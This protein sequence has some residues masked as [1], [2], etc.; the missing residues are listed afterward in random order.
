[1][2]IQQQ[3]A[4]TPG[5]IITALLNGTVQNPYPLYNS[6]RELDQGVHWAD[7]LDGWLCTRYADIRHIYSDDDTFSAKWWVDDNHN[8]QRAAADEHRRFLSIYTQQFML[9]DP[10][11]HTEIRS[12]LR[13]SFTP[14]RVQRW[15][16]VISKI[17]DELLDSLDPSFDIDVMTSFAQL[18][19]IAVIASMLGIPS[20]DT[21]RFREWTN[22][23][24]DTFD[25]RI[26]GDERDKRVRTTLE[27]FDYLADQV[28]RRRARP[29]DDL[30]TLL[31]TARLNDGSPLEVS[32]S[33]AQLALL[34]AAGNDTTANLIGS[35]M[36]LLI[37]NP[38]IQSELRRRTE[39]VP[40]AVEEMLRLDPPFH[41]I[42]RRVMKPIILGGR[43]L[44]P[45]QLCWQLLPAA[46]RDQRAFAEPDEFS[47]KPRS[48]AH[49]AFIHGIHFCLGAA[50]ARLEGQIVFS[51]LLRRYP[52]FAAGAKPPVRRT[53][54]TIARG[55]RTR[56]VRLAPGETEDGDP[57]EAVVD[58]SGGE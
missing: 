42:H 52:R 31:A 25:P 27:L 24:V 13:T 56:P 23:F 3:Q 48:N 46:N 45:G 51:T 36:T 26:Q 43:S 7:E 58:P 54:T 10:P 32:R 49:L 8:I 20:E 38:H 57:A 40:T 39:L 41:F 6:L 2:T 50:L 30:I 55:W 4:R 18:V 14:H 17:I 29:T 28:E 9:T 16:S 33:V 12:I 21:G 35:G 34:L 47:L 19:P 37:D 11:A 1:M 53:E 22:A 5:E 44:K 15:R